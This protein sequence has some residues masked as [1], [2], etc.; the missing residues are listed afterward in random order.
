MLFR[1]GTQKP[2]VGKNEDNPPVGGEQNH[3]EGDDSGIDDDVKNTQIEEKENDSTHS[4]NELVDGAVTIEKVEDIFSRMKDYIESNPAATPEAFL[5]EIYNI[6]YNDSSSLEK[7]ANN[8]LS[9]FGESVDNII[10]KIFN[11]Q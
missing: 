2:S 4:V 3:I 1:S 7:D 6:N 8:I 9:Q 11:I 5:K 10:T